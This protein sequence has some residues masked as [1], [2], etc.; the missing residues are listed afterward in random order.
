M[1]QAM[2]CIHG[3]KLN[4]HEKANNIAKLG[5]YVKKKKTLSMNLRKKEN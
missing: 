5:I 3:I 4:I 1:Q 2:T